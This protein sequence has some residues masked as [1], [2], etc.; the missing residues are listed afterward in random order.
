MEGILIIERCCRFVQNK[1]LNVLA[2]RFGDLHQLLL[3]HAQV[4]DQSIWIL[5]QTDQ[6]HD[7]LSLSAL[8]IILDEDPLGDGIAQKDILSNRHV[9]LECQLL[10][11]DNDSLALRISYAGELAGFALIDN[12]SRIGSIWVDSRQHVHESGFTSPI[13]AA[14]GEDLTLLDLDIDMVQCRDWTEG[15]YNVPHFQNRVLR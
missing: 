10:M 12:A 6:G 1:Q 14:D 15:L 4:G 8:L 9:G 2:E 13:F 11:D 7:V 3:A 5:F